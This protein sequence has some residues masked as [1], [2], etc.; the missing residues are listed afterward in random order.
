M[1]MQSELDPSSDKMIF[2]VLYMFTMTLAWLLCSFSD[3]EV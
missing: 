1:R 3:V 2:S